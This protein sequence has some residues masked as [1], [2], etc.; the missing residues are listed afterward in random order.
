MSKKRRVLLTGAAGRIGIAV[1][2]R[3]SERWDI[4]ATDIAGSGCRELDVTDAAAC[5]VA[6]AEVV[7]SSTWLVHQALMRNG[8]SCFRPMSSVCTA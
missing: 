3:L 2:D 5:R 6:F 7:R 1:T 8:M 4:V